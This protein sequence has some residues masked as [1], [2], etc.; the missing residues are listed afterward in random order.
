MMTHEHF[1]LNYNKSGFQVVYSV[2]AQ[3]L[4]INSLARQEWNMRKG[5][6][7][8]QG[9]VEVIDCQISCNASCIA[10]E[11]KPAHLRQYP[12]TLE[13]IRRAYTLGTQIET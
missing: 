2:T 1:H 11:C 10:C 3:L 5:G 13:H 4:Q 8:W 9:Y 6:G 12:T 7:H